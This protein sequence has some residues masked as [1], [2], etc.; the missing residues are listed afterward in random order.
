[1]CLLWITNRTI[2]IPIADKEICTQ[3]MFLRVLLSFSLARHKFGWQ[4]DTQSVVGNSSACLLGW[5]SGTYRE[6]SSLDCFLACGLVRVENCNGPLRLLGHCCESESFQGEES[7]LIKKG[8]SGWM[9]NR[10]HVLHLDIWPVGVNQ[11]HRHAEGWLLPWCQ[12]AGDSSALVSTG[13][14]WLFL[15]PWALQSCA[16]IGNFSQHLS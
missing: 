14:C 6:V 10:R 16:W 11:H 5:R 13:L 9:W 12:G 1:M 3:T 7:L 8:L 15:W 4:I 2:F